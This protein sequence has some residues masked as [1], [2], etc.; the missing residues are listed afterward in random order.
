MQFLFS[1]IL[2]GVL[3][4]VEMAFAGCVHKPVVGQPERGLASWYGQNH[5]GKRTA[6]GEIFNMYDLT[7]AHRT[8]PMNSRVKVTD[9]ISGRSVIVRINDRG[10][11]GR[12]RIVD[13][14]YE[15]AKR[16][17]FLQRG[18][19]EVTIELLPPL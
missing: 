8:L 1:R 4:L 16:L 14:S 3:I 18:T 17:G 11:F 6:S 9:L 10:P 15:A 7:A 5:Q 19:T 13:L 12:G 2:L